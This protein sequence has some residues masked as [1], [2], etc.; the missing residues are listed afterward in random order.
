MAVTLA[1][2]ASA[3]AQASLTVEPEAPCYR[4][5]EAV[6]LRGTGFTPNAVVNF[7][8][9]EVAI[10]PAQ[11]IRADP[12]GAFF[13]QLD[14]PGLLSGQRHLTYVA[15]DSTNPAISAQVR[16]LV[17]ATDVGLQPEGGPPHRLLTVRA[18]GFFRGRTLYAHVVRAGP[19]PG[20]ARNLRIGPVKGACKRVRARARLFRRDTAP[21]RYRVQFDTFRTYRANRAIETD[22]KVTVYRTADAARAAA[23]SPAS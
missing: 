8:R 4:E 17:T 15:T 1:V 5:R 3:A 23:V 6:Y 7:M 21:G 10:I 22:F 12:S 18:R 11:P 9:G 19:R 13:P 20:R 16:L 14:L 2:P